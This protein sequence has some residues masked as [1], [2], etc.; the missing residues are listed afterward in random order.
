[1]LVEKYIVVGIRRSRE[2]ITDVIK[3]TSY[4]YNLIINPISVLKEPR[5]DLFVDFGTYDTKSQAFNRLNDIYHNVPDVQYWSILPIIED[6]PITKARKLK[7]SRL[8][9]KLKRR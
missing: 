1:M 9:K 5:R 7:L 3:Q 8:T 4:D 2:V 6:V